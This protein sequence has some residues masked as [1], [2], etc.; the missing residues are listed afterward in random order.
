MS[1][2]HLIHIL[3]KQ[4]TTMNAKRTVLGREPARLNTRVINTRS[5]LVLLKAEAMVKPPM[6]NI[7]V[8]ENMTENTN[9]NID[10]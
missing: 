6:S 5:M 3:A 7:I 2:T 4:D 10:E 9:L 1:Q 8:G